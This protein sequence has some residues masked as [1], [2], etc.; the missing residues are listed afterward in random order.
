MCEIYKINPEISHIFL[1]EIQQKKGF[2]NW[3]RM[4]YDTKKFRQIFLSGS[5]ASLLS[6]ETG[7]V[8]S[9]RHITS[10]VFPLSFPEYRELP[11]G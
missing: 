9:G 10:E 3:I 2:E 8:L 7:R 11:L 4:L 5:S 6:Q 1:D